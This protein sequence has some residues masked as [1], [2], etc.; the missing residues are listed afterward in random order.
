MNKPSIEFF[1]NFNGKR[2]PRYISFTYLQW[3]TMKLT[4]Q[5]PLRGEGE[6]EGGRGGEREHRLR[7]V[8]DKD[9]T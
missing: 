4:S 8:V 7:K 5:Q 1:S 3:H 6:R 2:K 9:R